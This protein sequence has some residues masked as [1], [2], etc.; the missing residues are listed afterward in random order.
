MTVK[1]SPSWRALTIVCARLAAHQILIL[2]RGCGVECDTH[3]D[4]PCACAGRTD[5]RQF[6]K[7]AFWGIVYTCKLT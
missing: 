2:D 5:G 1:S 7:V 4:L 3:S 6:G